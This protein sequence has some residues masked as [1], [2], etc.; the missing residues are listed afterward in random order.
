MRILHIIHS[1]DPATGGPIA[2]ILMHHAVTCGSPFNVERE[3][4]T[5]DPPDA[6]WLTDLPLRTHALGNT[7]HFLRT[8]RKIQ[9]YGSGA[10]L[11]A[12]LRDNAERFDCAIIHGLWNAASLAARQVLPHSGLPY[13][14]FA[15]G[16]LDPWF[17]KRFPVKHA[18]KCLS[19]SI[20][21]GPLLARAR[22][23]LFTSEE[24]KQRAA[25][26]FPHHHYRGTVVGYGTADPALN[27]P[28]DPQAAREPYL[29][30]LGRLHRKKGVDMLLQAL[31]RI[32]APYRPTIRFTGPDEEGR[33]PFLREQSEALGLTRHV[34]W[35]GPAYGTDKADLF[36]KAEAFILPSHQENFGIAATEALAMAT[37]ALLS[38]QVAIARNVMQSGAGFIANDTLDGTYALLQRWQN[39]SETARRKMRSEARALFLRDYDINRNAP[40]LIATLQKLL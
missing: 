21:E 17:R 11:C 15:H 12:W 35:T 9:K 32:A 20:V 23:V 10:R 34:L 30:F 29:L 6:I 4:A 26:C 18:A 27:Q 33:L 13:F 3:I 37:P 19:W 7:H 39:T 14:V 31:S 1:T 8:P 16:M 28:V 40:H 38:D 25:G 5:L 2:G 22:S 24:E 36:R